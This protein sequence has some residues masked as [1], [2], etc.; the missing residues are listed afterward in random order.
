[1]CSVVTKLYIQ[2]MN[3]LSSIMYQLILNLNKHYFHSGISCLTTIRIFTKTLRMNDIMEYTKNE[4]FKYLVIEASH[5]NYYGFNLKVKKERTYA[6]AAW[7]RRRCGGSAGVEQDWRRRRQHLGG[8]NSSVASVAAVLARQWQGRRRQ[9]QHGS[10]SGG[11]RAV[12]A[13]RRQRGGG[14]VAV[15]AVRRQRGGGQRDGGVGQCSGSAAFWQRGGGHAGSTPGAACLAAAVEVWRQ[16]SISGGLLEIA[17]C[18]ACTSM[19]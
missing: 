4:N 6:M 19:E 3:I 8:G 10:G 15:V 2:Y 14:S 18:A 17:G 5:G 11:S 13:R 7:Q 1:L 12:A 9:W 16:H